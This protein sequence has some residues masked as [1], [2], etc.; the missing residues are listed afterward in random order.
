LGYGDGDTFCRTL[1][2]RV[3]VA[4]IPVSAFAAEKRLRHLVRF[5]FC[6]NDATLEKTLQ[7]LRRLKN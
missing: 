6:K 5:A 7:R 1:V 3:G 4:A 2:E